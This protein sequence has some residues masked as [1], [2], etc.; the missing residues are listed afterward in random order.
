M[1]EAGWGEA[2]A[3]ARADEADGVG[4]GHG[5][6]QGEGEQKLGDGDCRL[7]YRTNM[8]EVLG[9]ALVIYLGSYYVGVERSAG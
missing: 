4:P 6:P 5:C 7:E 1:T 3:G 9:M 2:Q 8:N